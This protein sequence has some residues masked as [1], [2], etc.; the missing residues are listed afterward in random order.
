MMILLVVP[1][2]QTTSG[3]AFGQYAGGKCLYAFP[4]VCCL[5]MLMCGCETIHPD[6]PVDVPINKDAGRGGWL[7]VNL[8]V[9]SAKEF[10]FILDTG[11]PL[12]VIDRT[13]EPG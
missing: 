7:L 9:D 8:R 12:T 3:E 13:L 4:G 6:L 2:P 11:S 5:L 10:C 1:I